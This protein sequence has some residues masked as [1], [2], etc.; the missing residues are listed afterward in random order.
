MIAELRVA[1][2]E[3]S[4]YFPLIHLQP[5]MRERYGF[6]EGLCPIAED[7]GGRTLALPFY[8]QLEAEDQEWVIEALSNAVA[9]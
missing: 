1:G 5:Y 9:T 2:V 3:T 8:P 4:R 7:V 6:A